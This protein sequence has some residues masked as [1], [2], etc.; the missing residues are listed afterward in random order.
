MPGASGS[1]CSRPASSCI[2][3]PVSGFSRSREC[4]QKEL[5][6]RPLVLSEHR[7]FACL[8]NLLCAD[9][10]HRNLAA[11]AFDTSHH[12]RELVLGLCNTQGAMH[13]FLRAAGPPAIIRPHAWVVRA[14]VWRLP[15]L[16][17][18][19]RWSDEAFLFQAG[20]SVREIPVHPR[21]LGIDRVQAS[22]IGPSE[23]FGARLVTWPPRLLAKY[24]MASIQ[25]EAA[26]LRIEQQQQK[27]TDVN[28]PKQVKCAPEGTRHALG[29][30]FE[31]PSLKG[32]SSVFS[33]W[34]D[35]PEPKSPPHQPV[36]S[37][38][39][40]AEPTNAL[41]S[42]LTSWAS[43]SAVLHEP[44]H[45]PTE[46]SACWFGV[47]AYNVYYERLLRRIAEDFPK[48]RYRLK[49]SALMHG[50]MS[51]SDRLR[52]ANWERLNLHPSLRKF[53]IRLKYT[54]RHN[55]ASR[56]KHSLATIKWKRIA[57]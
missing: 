8:R 12:Q 17:C 30:L 37:S 52:D 18:Y 11:E 57:R 47:W 21:Q 54:Q 14:A 20:V 43:T 31:A 39:A 35:S 36:S 38:H 32:L 53:L 51:W 50:F 49:L 19:Q 23:L 10:M 2:P 40:E 56:A 24:E 25:L 1:R 5:L 28:Q 9:W 42:L 27:G 6:E 48:K 34:S 44:K 45:S 33:P 13:Q 41:D 46:L 7:L 4:S 3:R 16:S 22:L 29:D 26:L 55:T 15:V